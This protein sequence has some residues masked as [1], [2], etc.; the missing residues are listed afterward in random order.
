ML[1]RAHNIVMGAQLWRFLAVGGLNTLIGYS[2]ILALLW[3][4]VSDI[5]ANLSGYI[6]GLIISFILNRNWTFDQ[7]SSPSVEEV[8]VFFI[9]FA[10]AYGCNLYLITAAN[11]ADLS[12]NPLVHLAG[13]ILYT[14]VF[15]LFNR[16]Y[17]YPSIHKK[18]LAQSTVWPEY[19]ALALVILV[20][21]F[22]LSLQLT[23]D[24][25][26]QFWIA[27]QISE[28]VPLYERIMEINPPLWFWLALPFHM[29][30]TLLGVEADRFYI[31]FITLSALWASIVTGRFFS[32]Q[33]HRKRALIIVVSLVLMLIA[34]LYDFGQR[35]Q[36]SA[37]FAL[38]YCGL[39]YARSR[40]VPIALPFAILIGVCAALGFA[41]KH[42][43]VLVPIILELWYLQRHRNILRSFRPETISLAI[44][45]IIYAI[46]VVIITPTF[47]TEI[48]P[49]VSAAYGGYEKPWLFQIARSEFIAWVFAAVAY[50][51]LRPA[52]QKDDKDVADILGLAG[53]AFIFSYFAQQKGWQYHAIPGAIYMSLMMVH[54]LACQKDWVSFSIKKPLALIAAMIFVTVGITRGPYNSEWALSMHKRL[55]DLPENSSVMILTVDPR[56]VFPFVEEYKLLW[57][58]RHFAHWMLSSI[59]F[60]HV[61]L[62]GKSMTPELERLSDIV[63]EQAWEDMQCYPPKRILIQIRNNGEALHPERFYMTEFFRENTN[64]NQYLSENYKLAA[65]DKLFETYS[66]ITPMESQGN[67]CYPISVKP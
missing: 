11:M 14:G 9:A 65:S 10:F 23:H 66:R 63:R 13:V 3:A 50:I 4:G 19:L 5:P 46:A 32:A 12:G 33:N 52:L 6:I 36:L 42:Y 17:V 40:S 67:N 34:P 7:K 25:S 2:V 45:A 58:S 59:S 31:I 41:L 15:F 56:R 18:G 60:A 20:L 49:M 39:I 24:V 28:G 21:P 57:P 61:G 37:I 29:L 51:S 22:L 1:Q 54:C 55:S 43:F 47:F 16:F 26:W 35:E 62:Y 27:R 53:I 8:I 64:F 48:V 30:G 44:C 38:P